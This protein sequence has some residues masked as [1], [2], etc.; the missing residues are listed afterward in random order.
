MPCACSY[1]ESPGTVHSFTEHTALESVHSLFLIAHVIHDM[2]LLV[3]YSN[4]ILTTE[5]A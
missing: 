1:T 4:S 3:K 5:A 2:I